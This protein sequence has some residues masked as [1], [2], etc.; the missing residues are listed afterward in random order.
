MLSSN[1]YSQCIAV[2]RIDQSAHNLYLGLGQLATDICP[3]SS[4]PCSS[5]LHPVVNAQHVLSLCQQC[6]NHLPHRRINSSLSM[7][8]RT[9][10]H[11]FI[12]SSIEVDFIMSRGYGMHWEH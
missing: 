6:T 9:W 10:L 1:T 2:A 7:N 5:R 8:W 4:S 3:A 11:G 12:G